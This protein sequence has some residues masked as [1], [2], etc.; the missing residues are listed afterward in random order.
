MESKLLS[1]TQSHSF[2]EYHRTL[3]IFL[4]INY[5][6]QQ[7]CSLDGASLIHVYRDEKTLDYILL[8][9]PRLC[10]HIAYIDLEVLPYD[11]PEIYNSLVRFEHIFCNDLQDHDRLPWFV[12]WW[13]RYVGRRVEGLHNESFDLRKLC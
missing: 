12:D 7:I 3:E 10:Y 13:F 2:C 4:G 5:E 1:D 6:S 11:I 9:S 8:S